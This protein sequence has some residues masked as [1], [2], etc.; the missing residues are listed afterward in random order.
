MKRNL[1]GMVVF[2]VMVT[3][4]SVA[5][6]AFAG[7]G[8]T[9]RPFWASGSQ[10]CDADGCTGPGTATQLGRL[11]ITSTGAGDVLTAANGDQ[12]AISL[13]WSTLQV[14]FPGVA[15]CPSTGFG[16]RLDAAVTGGTG[17]FA[18]AS[19]AVKYIAC[20]SDEVHYTFFINGAI[21]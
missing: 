1:R 20:S 11:T 17:R 15:P 4:L 3:A 8:G 7:S 18:N 19:G 12:I 21:S 9:N 14:D 2:A 6:P 10:A 5:A 13:D 16:A